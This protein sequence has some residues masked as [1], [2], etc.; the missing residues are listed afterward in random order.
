MTTN[1]N[2]NHQIMKMKTEVNR[3]KIAKETSSGSTH[4]FQRMSPITLVNISFFYSF[5]SKTFSKQ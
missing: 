1:Y 3:L 5:N 4:L 2:T